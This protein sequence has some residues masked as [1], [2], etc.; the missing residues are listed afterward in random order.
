LLLVDADRRGLA[1]EFFLPSGRPPGEAVLFERLIDGW[2]D[3]VAALHLY[4]QGRYE[5]GDA[6]IRQSARTIGQAPGALPGSLQ[7]GPYGLGAAELA[8][9]REPIAAAERVP[10]E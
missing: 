8:A 5:A 1:K 3:Y 9:L 4:A 10:P 7:E 6:L 2:A